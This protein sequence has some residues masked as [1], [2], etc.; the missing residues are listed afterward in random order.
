MTGKLKNDLTSRQFGFLKVLRRSLD[1]GN[2]KKPVVKW[3]CRCKCGNIITVKSDSLLSNHTIS[4]GCKKII[5]GKSNKE[6]LY[7]TWKNMRQRCNNPNRSDYPR[8]GGRGVRICN[9][10]NE[11]S[12]F[13]AWALSNGYADNL[14][15]DRIDVNGNYEPSNCRW[16]DNFV[17]ANN[18]RNN[19]MITFKNNTYTMAEFA[20]K[21][22]ISYSTLQHRLD[23]G[24]T[25]DK[26]VQ[27]PQRGV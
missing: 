19:R 14:S 27:T 15:I 26:I 17:Q 3:E 11:Y 5:H 16:V 22:G 2:G 4:C 24:W 6:R 7:Q 9:E 8:Y 1:K 23:R 10:W 18:V 25:I 21:I 20:R 12:N 13:R